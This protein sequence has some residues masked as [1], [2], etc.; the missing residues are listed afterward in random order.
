MR[1]RTTSVRVVEE[2]C[3]STPHTRIDTHRSGCSAPLVPFQPPLPQL[4]TSNSYLPLLKTFPFPSNRLHIICTS[5]YYHC[6]LMS[7]HPMNH[8][9]PTLPC[10]NPCRKHLPIHFLPFF[11]NSLTINFINAIRIIS[12]ST[13]LQ[14]FGY[15]FLTLEK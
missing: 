5:M 1:T 11:N 10:S 4:V 14:F 12:I 6:D 3:T 8:L 15:N 7:L 13:L 2:F 9:N